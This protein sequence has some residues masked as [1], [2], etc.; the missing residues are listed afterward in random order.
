MIPTLKEFI[1]S[2]KGYI[3]SEG[4]VADLDESDIIEFAKMHVTEAL[5]QAIEKAEINITHQEKTKRMRYY[6]GDLDIEAEINKESILT[7]YNLDN[8]K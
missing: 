4:W 5:R 1:K 2:K 6:F 3:N 8:I 7:S